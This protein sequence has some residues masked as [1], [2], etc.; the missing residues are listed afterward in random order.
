MSS[1]SPIVSWTSARLR[2]RAAS[3]SR[4]PTLRARA[5][6]CGSAGTARSR[7]ERAARSVERGR[8][9]ATV[10]H[11]APADRPPRL[12]SRLRQLGAVAGVSQ[13]ARPR[14]VRG[15]L[16]RALRRRQPAPRRRAAADAA[17]RRHHLGARL[18][19]DPVRRRAQE[20]RAS[21]TRSASTC[22]FRFRPGR[23]SWPSPSTRSSRARSPPTI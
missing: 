17:R 10:D 20:A 18:P 9:H 12:L 19:P 16:L 11:P 3:P 6:P 1:W 4:S 5:A 2:R 21:P 13:P 14:P 8:A 7:R 22:T 23:P 15:R